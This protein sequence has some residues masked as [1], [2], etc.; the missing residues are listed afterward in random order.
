[1]FHVKHAAWIGH[2]AM[3]HVKRR[4]MSKQAWW[5]IAW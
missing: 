5:V 4:E 1:M 2:A 3:F